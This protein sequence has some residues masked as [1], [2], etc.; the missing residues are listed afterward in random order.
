MRRRTPKPAR[1]G[2]LLDP[3][4]IEIPGPDHP[5]SALAVLGSGQDFLLD[6]PAHGCF[7]DIQD[8]GRLFQRD[9]ATLSALPI[10]IRRNAAMIAQEADPRTGP[11]IAAPVVL[12]A[13]LRIGAIALSGSCRASAVT[14]STTSASVPQRCWPVRFLR[15]RIGV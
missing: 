8:F 4:I 6:E 14:S 15:T 2:S 9:L 3:G 1:I 7:A 10:T 5:G 11:A 13:R 12:P